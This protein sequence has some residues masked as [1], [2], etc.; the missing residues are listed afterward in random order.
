MR[1]KVNLANRPF[2]NHRLLWAGVA[3]AFL[4]GVWFWL[5]VSA[6]KSRVMAQA[7]MVSA[8]IKENEDRVRQ[9]REERD[10]Q[11][12]ETEKVILSE[13]DIAQLTSAR[14]LV[15]RKGFSWNRLIS[16]IER[17]VPNRV[18]I[19]DIR[20]QG[21]TDE[22]AGSLAS[23][24]INALGETAAQ[25][26]EMLTSLEKSGGLFTTEQA[27]QMAVDEANEVPFK[28]SLVYRPDR[29]GTL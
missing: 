13:L 23:V 20:L 26:T 18:R 25:M 6:E 4:L 29:G 21:V 9:I 28:L 7:E 24:E 8:N 27:E 1:L 3:I 5:W 14:Q 17:F 19:T 12:Q 10:K 22:S 15:L 11:K 2:T 16:D